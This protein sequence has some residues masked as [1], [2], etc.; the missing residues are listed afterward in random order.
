M[1]ENKVSVVIPVY[2]SAKFLSESIESVLSQTYQNIEIIAIDD[3]STDQSVEILEQYSDK[4]KFL[5]QPNQ[6][7]SFALNN[8]L[9]QIH[10]YYS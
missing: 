5:T 10:N 7:L 9:T 3:G 2:N 4:I 8:A 6:G 1:K